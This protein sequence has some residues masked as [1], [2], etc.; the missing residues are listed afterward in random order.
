MIR[1]I[2]GV[3][4]G[5][6][7]GSVANLGII[8]IS[9]ALWPPPE[10]FDPFSADPEMQEMV[11]AHFAS[12]PAPAFLVVW[13]AHWF[14]TLVGAITATLIHGRVKGRQL[15]L[16]LDMLSGKRVGNWTL[17]SRT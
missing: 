6:V 8:E 4:V 11:R 9:N 16:S 3:I 1:A 12:L 15:K 14:G 2:V 10:G 5:V 13:V 7:V 17:E